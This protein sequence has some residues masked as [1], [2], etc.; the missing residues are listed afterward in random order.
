M[1]TTTGILRAMVIVAAGIAIA[2]CG[3]HQSEVYQRPPGEIRQL[4]HTVEV[5]LYMFGGS[6]D[7]EAIVDSSSSSTIIWKI[8]ADASPLMTFTATL[9]PEGE[10]AARVVVAVEGA[11]VGKYGDVKARLEKMHEIKTLYLVSMTEAIDSTLDG[12]AYDITRTYPA[13]IA[14]GT[15]NSGH[16]FP[17]P[18]RGSGPS[19]AENHR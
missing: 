1:Q 13:L 5:P 7:T 4:L 11:R 17:Q 9:L 6:A 10:T 2:A 18:D 14:A 8:T 3:K 16:L 19:H 15:A 12:R